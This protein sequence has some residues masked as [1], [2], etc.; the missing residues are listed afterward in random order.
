MTNAGEVAEKLKPL[1]T[2]DGNVKWAAAMEN[3]K[4]GPQ[5]NKNKIN[6]WSR[7]STSE[8]IPKNVESRVLKRYSSTND[9]SSITQNS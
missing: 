1:Y 2:A 8:F 3:S 4:M 5:K 6:I 9:H 7:N